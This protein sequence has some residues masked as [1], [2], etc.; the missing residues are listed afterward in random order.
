MKFD[1][2]LVG[3]GLQGALVALAV[4]ERA[5]SARLAVVEAGARLGGNHT[6]SFHAGDLSPAMERVV[7]PLVA[8]RW[9]AWE[10]AFPQLSRRFDRPYATITSERLHEVVSARLAAAPGARLWLGTFAAEVGGDA[11]R[12]ASGEVVEGGVVVDARGPSA[13]SRRERAERAAAA[14]S[15]SRP[16]GWQKFLGLELELARPIDRAVPLVMDARVEQVDGFRFVYALP[17]GPRRALV[18]DTYYA[19]DPAIDAPA[20]EAR[21]LAWAG[22][23]GWDVVRVVRRERGTLPLPFAPFRPDVAGGPLAAGYRGGWFHPTT[24]YSLPPA[25]R[26]A[27]A[28]AAAFPARP[29]PEALAA[30]AD[31][32]A[33][34]VRF[35]TLLNRLMFRATPPGE[36]WH[37][38]ERFHA[39]P[40]ATV[41]RFYAMRTTALDRARLLVGRPPRGVSVGRAF[42]ELGVRRGEA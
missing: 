27:E 35:F 33:R 13:P 24:G 2:V 41:E 31:A 7:A 6:W 28:L 11:V 39:L 3:G 32:H 30:L 5:P 23:A 37:A 42:L 25:A 22:A 40:E 9:P 4:L 18:E 29:S 26:L 1:L 17:L 8:H 12:L 38:L 14:R 15:R 34:Q 21:A 16:C 19:D 20:L 36:R 10:V